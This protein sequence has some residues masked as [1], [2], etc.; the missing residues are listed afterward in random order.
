MNNHGLL[1]FLFLFRNNPITGSTLLTMSLALERF[2]TVCFPFFKLSHRYSFQLTHICI[3]IYY[4]WPA[5]RYIIPICCISFFYSD[6]RNLK[7][8]NTKWVSQLFYTYIMTTNLFKW[9]FLES[10]L[11]DG[12]DEDA[13]WPICLWVG[14]ELLLWMKFPKPIN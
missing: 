11:D 9:L 12:W 10:C 3:L 1:F 6:L 14:T 7:W 13:L 5:S 4:R 8:L 2:V